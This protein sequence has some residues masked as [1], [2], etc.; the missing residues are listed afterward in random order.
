MNKKSIFCII[1]LCALL[2]CAC[3][4]EI[5]FKGDLKISFEIP[6]SS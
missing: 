2:F 4:K 3:E 5:E 1:L 6:N